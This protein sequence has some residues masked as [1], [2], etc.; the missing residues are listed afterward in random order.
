MAWIQKFRKSGISLDAGDSAS[1]AVVKRSVLCVFIYQL[2]VECVF[3]LWNSCLR[4]KIP[5]YYMWPLGIKLYHGWIS[6]M[7]SSNEISWKLPPRNEE[8]VAPLVLDIIFSGLWISKTVSNTSAQHALRQ[9]SLTSRQR[10]STGPRNC[11]MYTDGDAT[12]FLI[13]W[14]ADSFHGSKGARKGGWVKT[15]LLSLRFYKPL[16]PAQRRWIV[17]AHFLLVNLST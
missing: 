4:A 6:T 10:T 16:L 8:L 2:C 9:W 13:M 15:T 1:N 14:F 7:T 3:V 11:K 12:R 17:F 5:Y